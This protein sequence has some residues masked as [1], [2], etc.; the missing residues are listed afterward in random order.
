M[1][2]RIYRY[3]SIFYFTIILYSFFFIKNIN[4]SSPP[5]VEKNRKRIYIEISSNIYEF[6]N[7]VSLRKLFNIKSN[8]ILKN[9]SKIDIF[10]DKDGSIKLYISNMNPYK[11]L[12]LSIPIN[13][14]RASLDE[15]EAIP[16]IGSTL[17]YRIWEYRNNNGRFKNL[18]KLMD[19][20]GISYNRYKKIVKYITIN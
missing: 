7:P 9:G 17:A 13:I 3:E 10:K 6:N 16:Y 4:P 20:E 5:E 2:E 18:N 14:N 15:I 12:T 8:Y 19:I 11:L 1:K